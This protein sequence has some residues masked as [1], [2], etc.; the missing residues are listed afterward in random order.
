MV[1]CTSSTLAS[2]LSRLRQVRSPACGSPETSSTRILSRMPSIGSTALLLTSVSSPGTAEASISTMFGPPWP[3]SALDRRRS[4]RPA[5]SRRS[6][7]WPS[8]RTTTDG[9]RRHARPLVDR[10]GSAPSAACRRCRS[11]APRSAR[12]GG[13]ARRARPVTR[14]CIGAAKPSAAALA[15]MSWTTPSVIRMAPPTRS[16]GTSASALESA[17]NRAVPS[18]SAPLAA[19]LDDADLGI[20]EALEAVGERVA[21]PHSVCSVRSAERLRGRAI[22]DHGDDV[23]QDVAVL[24]RERGV[25]ERQNEQRQ[26]R[27][28]QPRAAQPRREDGERQNEPRRQRGRRAPARAAAARRTGQVRSLAEP[29]EQGRHMDLVGLVVAGQRIHH[30]VDAGAIGQLALARTAGRHRDRAGSCRRRRPRR[31]RGRSR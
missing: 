2:A 27:G 18:L 14:A 26:R 6:I 20:A 25:G 8:R 15:G 9:R 19:G 22:D 30:E 17:P 4:G 23:R 31:R 21:R 3:I 5:R 10:P 13:R 7:S 16:G 24:T 12:C 11:A 29:L 1:K 28:A